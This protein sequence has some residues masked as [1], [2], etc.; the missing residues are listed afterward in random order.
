MNWCS[1]S[2]SG[3]SI[4]DVL[5][6]QIDIL[7]FLVLRKFVVSHSMMS[8]FLQFYNFLMSIFQLFKTE[9]DPLRVLAFSLIFAWHP[10]FKN[11]VKFSLV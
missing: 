11:S 7:K 4:P 6:R 5:T 10:S 8:H 1:E 9:H 2:P 3:D